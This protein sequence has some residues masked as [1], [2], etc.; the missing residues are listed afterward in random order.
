M[1][2]KDY[3][4]KEVLFYK[5]SVKII[6]ERPYSPELTLGISLTK[7]GGSYQLILTAND[8]IIFKSG[9]LP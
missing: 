1:D 4:V 3:K 8:I 6:L 2:I 7:R 9:L 5:D